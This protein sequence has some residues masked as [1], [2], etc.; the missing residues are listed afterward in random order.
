MD[1]I[2]KEL[3]RMG[4]AETIKAGGNEYVYEWQHSVDWDGR[5]QFWITSYNNWLF[6]VE[7]AKSGY[8]TGVEGSSR[9]TSF[10]GYISSKSA[11]KEVKEYIKKHP[12]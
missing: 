9:S 7:S 5:Y 4:F 2:R 10:Y 12:L 11:F 1:I 8:A 3:K 6:R